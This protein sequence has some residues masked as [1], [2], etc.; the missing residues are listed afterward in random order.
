MT[1]AIDSGTALAVS[2]L[3]KRLQDVHYT[4]RS[5]GHLLDSLIDAC[6]DADASIAA[7]ERRDALIEAMRALLE[8][9]EVSS[10]AEA[11]T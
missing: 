10:A 6:A 8:K 4:V 3:A 5:T 1:N 7:A 2:C 9:A 11:Q